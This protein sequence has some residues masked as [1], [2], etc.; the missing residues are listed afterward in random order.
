MQVIGEAPSFHCAACGSE[1]PIS[2][3]LGRKYPVCSVECAREMEWRDTLA[4]LDKPY[5]LSADM[6][7]RFDEG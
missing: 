1:L 3:R 5:S 7:S 2:R 6:K 4:I